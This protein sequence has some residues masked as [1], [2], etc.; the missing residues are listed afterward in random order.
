MGQPF[1]NLCAAPCGLGVATAASR[2]SAPRDL[3]LSPDGRY[4]GVSGGRNDT[5]DR[6]FDPVGEK[7]KRIHH[8]GTGERVSAGLEPSQ[9]NRRRHLLGRVAVSLTPRQGRTRQLLR[10]YSAVPLPAVTQRDYS[11]AHKVVWELIANLD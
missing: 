8:S 5:R 11:P 10:E 2:A 9:A 1:H 7:E 6:M 4:P 3:G